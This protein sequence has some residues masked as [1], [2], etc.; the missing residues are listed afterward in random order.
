[1]YLLLARFATRRIALIA[2]A[3][4]SATPMTLYFGGFPDPIGML[5]VLFVLLATI[6][7]LSAATKP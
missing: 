1:L 7:T 5:L 6:D 3:L 2:A 4:F